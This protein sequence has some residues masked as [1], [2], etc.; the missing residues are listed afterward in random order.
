M[1]TFSDALTFLKAGKRVH[2]SGWNGK[3]MFLFRVP[4]HKDACIE[5]DGEIVEFRGHI[6]MK[7]APGYIVPWLAS[8]TDL[9]DEDWEVA[10]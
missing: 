6:M 4:A 9:L 7:T 2:R 10:P 8:Q 3:G 5:M 1:L